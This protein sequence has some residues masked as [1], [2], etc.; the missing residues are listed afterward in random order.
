M[1][2]RTMTACAVAAAATVLGAG[3]AF[4]QG[5]DAI[6][7]TWEEYDAE[8]GEYVHVDFGEDGQV[9]IEVFDYH[10]GFYL[11]DEEL[12]LIAV[13][14]TE[15]EREDL[16]EHD[17]VEY[18]LKGNKL[19]IIA[20]PEEAM[21]FLRVDRPEQAAS[22]IVGSWQFDPD[23]TDFDWGDDAPPLMMLTFAN[24][25]T[26]SYRELDELIEG[27]FMVDAELGTM[28]LTIEDDLDTASYTIE[29]DTLTLTAHDE[30]HV[31]T[32]VE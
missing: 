22:A 6:L 28:E 30:T 1:L 19:T 29:G 25:G 2:K 10:E 18:K 7:G 21:A 17:W 15:E 4:G 14:E 13:Y 24:D 16:S 5:A 26:A 12:H 3:V 8:R 9:A 11:L 31:L 20:G 27:S 32:R 23:K